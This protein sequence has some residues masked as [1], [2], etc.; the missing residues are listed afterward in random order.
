MQDIFGYVRNTNSCGIF[1]TL[2]ICKN[3]DLQVLLEVLSARLLEIREWW[4]SGGLSERGYTAAEVTH[5]ITALF[6]DTP[7]RRETLQ[8]ID[9]GR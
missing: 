4:D 7:L 9:R 5:L 3:L 6:E 8:H 1:S 2:R